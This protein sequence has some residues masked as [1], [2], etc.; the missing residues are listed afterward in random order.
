MVRLRPEDLQDSAISVAH[1]LWKE[2][3]DH[4]PAILSFQSAST[5]AFCAVAGIN[6]FAR[7]LEGF[8]IPPAY[9]VHLRSLERYSEDFVERVREER[10][11][12]NV[13]A[14]S[15]GEVVGPST[16]V[17][18]LHGRL[19]SLLFTYPK[20]LALF[21]ESSTEFTRAFLEQSG[22]VQEAE[23]SWDVRCSSTSERVLELVEGLGLSRGMGS[24][25]VHR[26]L[27]G[28]G[29]MEHDLVDFTRSGAPA[30]ARSLLIR[31]ADNSAVCRPLPDKTRSAA[32]HQQSIGEIGS[33]MEVVEGSRKIE[34]R[35]LLRT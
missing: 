7:W 17:L 31:Y 15:E 18:E 8:R 4:V 6:E 16:P 22:S 3:L 34:V 28:D 30:D 12:L 26:L 5:Q 33:P 10:A 27:D 1:Q 21:S 13:F 14:V 2:G 19:M 29:M 20:A 9:L 25:H 35:V 11:I 24:A 32:Y 23:A